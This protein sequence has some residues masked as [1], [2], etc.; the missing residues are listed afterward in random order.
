[1]DRGTSER[2]KR[3]PSQVQKLR[4]DVLGKVMIPDP[5]FEEGYN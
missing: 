3:G 5:S 4:E 1:M 2:E